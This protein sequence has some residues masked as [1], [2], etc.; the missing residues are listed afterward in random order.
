MSV[1]RDRFGH[2]LVASLRATRHGVSGLALMIVRD[3][4]GPTGARLR[5]RYYRRRLASLGPGTRIDEGVH[6]VGA[7]HVHIGSNCWIAANAF[8][9][10]GPTG[11]QH[12]EV[13]NR[14]NDDYLGPEGELHLGDD[15]YVGPQVYVNA[16]GG[17]RVGKNVA[18]SVGA[19]IFSASHYHRSSGGPPGKPTYAGGMGLSANDR[20]A[21]LLGPVVIHDRAFVGAN[22]VVLPGVTIGPSSWLGAGAVA[23]E[24]VQPES[25]HS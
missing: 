21:L 8:L 22:A 11:K 23:R 1:R 17:V 12:R 25:I 14:P 13:I 7:D 24:D 20:Q 19:K 18:L 3:Y 9:A 16:H 15:V 6:I 2:R 4:P 10:A 5:Y